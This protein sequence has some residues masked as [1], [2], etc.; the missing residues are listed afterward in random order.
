MD[1]P[2]SVHVILLEK[3]IIP[4]EGIDLS[5]VKPGEYV[6]SAFPINLEGADGS[7]VRAVLLEK[8]GTD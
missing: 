3:G 4:L 6:L 1:H 5:A 7:P 8:Q 2:L